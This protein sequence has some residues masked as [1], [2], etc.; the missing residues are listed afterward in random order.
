M[1]FSLFIGNVST[2][3]IL[4]SEVPIKGD[5]AP[6]TNYFFFYFNNYST[7][8]LILDL[9]ISLDRAYKYLK[10]CLRGNILG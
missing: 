8:R 2:A 5:P 10:L 3:R 7:T 9:K 6:E 1:V 4:P